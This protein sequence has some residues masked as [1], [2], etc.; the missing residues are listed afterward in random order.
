MDRYDSITCRTV[1]VF[2]HCEQ[3]FVVACGTLTE[4]YMAS[5]W[6]L[7]MLDQQFLAAPHMCSCKSD[8]VQSGWSAYG[9][10]CN[11]LPV[12]CG[13][14]YIHCQR[15]VGTAV[16]SDTDL[17]LI[18]GL[19]KQVASISCMLAACYAWVVTQYLTVSQSAAHVQYFR[20]KG[21]TNSEMVCG[22]CWCPFGLWLV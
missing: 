20:I 7:I 5:S 1:C 12:A 4:V 17:V 3:W 18:G 6:I 22:T 10:T 9:F 8:C 19:Y 21:L 14:S 16:C 15:H 13:V 2:V 11:S